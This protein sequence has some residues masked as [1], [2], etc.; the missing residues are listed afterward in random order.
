[1][2]VSDDDLRRIARTVWATQLGIELANADAKSVTAR[3]PSDDT[4]TVVVRFS[5]GFT[6]SLVQQCSSEAARIAAGA[7]FRPSGRE[8]EAGDVRDT[9][10]ELAH[11]TAG[12]LKSVLAPCAVSLPAAEGPPEDAAAVEAEAAFVLGDGALLLRLLSA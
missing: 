8:V 12:N 5:G 10:A 6:G 3:L 1:M 11:V 2:R 4:V 7:A 9:V